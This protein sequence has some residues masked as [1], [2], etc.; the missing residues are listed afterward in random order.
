M[1][2]TLPRNYLWIA[3]FSIVDWQQQSKKTKIPKTNETLRVCGQKRWWHKKKMTKTVNCLKSMSINE[4]E[5]DFV[6]FYTFVSCFK[7]FAVYLYFHFWIYLFNFVFF[8]L[9]SVSRFTINNRSVLPLLFVIFTLWV[10]SGTTKKSY[11]SNELMHEHMEIE[12]FFQFLFLHEHRVFK[13]Q[14]TH[15]GWLTEYRWNELKNERKKKRQCERIAQVSNFN[16]KR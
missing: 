13:L 1:C 16:L 6:R 3:P 4:R 12:L 14:F 10:K 15:T 9:F 5:R 8:F 2:K 11:S 7:V